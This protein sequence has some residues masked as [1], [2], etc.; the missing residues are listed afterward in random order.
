M[1]LEQSTR[2]ERM[3]DATALE[4]QAAIRA[5][6]YTAAEY[7]A[8]LRARAAQ[9]R[10]YCSLSLALTD[11]QVATVSAAP[12]GGLVAGPL[13]EI[14]LA[15]KDCFD[16]VGVPT[17]A[18]T[19]ALADN[20]AVDNAPLV[21][22]L[23]AGGA[24]IVAKTVMHELSFGG[25]SRNG[26]HGTPKNPWDATRICGGSSGGAASSVALGIVPAGIGAD[27]GGSV[28]VPAALNGII[29]FR[30][31]VG[32]YPEGGTVPIS[33]TRDAAGPLARSMADIVALDAVLA[34]GGVAQEAAPAE[35]ITLGLNPGH[36]EGLDPD[37]RAVFTAAIERLRVRGVEIRTVDVADLIDRALAIAFTIVWGEVAD[38]LTEYLT[39]HGK[40]T[41]DAVVA[42]IADPQVAAAFSAHLGS[43]TGDEYAAAVRELDALREEFAA[44]LEANGVE[45]L[46]YPTTPVVAPRIGEDDTILVNGESE[47]T[48]PT[49]IRHAEFGGTLGL[50]GISLPAGLGPDSGLPVGVEIALPRGRDVRLLSIAS[51]LE[52]T[53]S[54]I[55]KPSA[56]IPMHV[57]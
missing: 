47:L 27:T 25:T 19:P 24:V 43:V 10:E 7:R 49:L 8:V 44:R 11:A 37:V 54:H 17:S 21:Q 56:L 48:F 23:A 38:A 52:K 41:L 29:G 16:V 15:V 5:G 28:R 30:P 32:R 9:V 45:G 6:E 50:P 18:G 20:V 14:P 42:G 39:S 26:L 34:G 2:A 57:E 3:I 4:A 31:S 51:E 1:S 13:A 35:T 12:A 46:I 22:Q 55:T 36:F 33:P 40:I 53:L